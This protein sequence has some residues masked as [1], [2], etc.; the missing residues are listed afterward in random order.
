MRPYLFTTILLA[1]LTMSAAAAPAWNGVSEPAPS[2]AAVLH[3]NDSYTE[4]EFT[5][6]G[7][8]SDF[9]DGEY[10]FSFDGNIY[11]D[12]PSYTKMIAIPEYREVRVELAD[13]EYE[14]INI[15]CPVTFRDERIK[16]GRPGMMRDIRIVPVTVFPLRQ[17]SEG[18]IE[19]LKSARIK[20]HY[21]GYSS[22][23]NKISSRPRSSAFE[24][25]YEKSVLNYEWLDGGFEP[26]GKGTYLV[27]I[28]ESFAQS[29]QFYDWIEWKKM[30]GFHVEVYHPAYDM[31]PEELLN[32]ITGYYED[33][34][35]PL[36]Y[37]ILIGDENENATGRIQ[38]FHV[39]H[40][41]EPSEYDVT[42][43][44]YTTL[45][46]D[47]IFSD[48]FIGRISVSTSFEANKVFIKMLNY[49]KTPYVLETQWYEQMLSVAG[50]YNDSGPAPITP[51]QTAWWIADEFLDHGYTAADTIFYWGPWDPNQNHEQI[52]A[53]INAGKAFVT[54]RGWADANGWQ[55]PYYNIS[56]LDDLVNLWKLPVVLS[57]VCNTGDFGSTN[58]PVCFGEEF[59]RMGTPQN[60]N[61]AIAFLGPSDLHTNT[62]YNNTLST[63]MIQ[64]FLDLGLG[65]F[66][67]ATAY[68]KMTLFEGYP[69]DEHGYVP[70]YFSVYNCLGDPELEMW[71]L[72]PSNLSL[73]CPGTL[74]TGGSNIT[75]YV[76]SG[77]VP[78]EGAYVSALHYGELI[79]GDFTNSSGKVMLAFGPVET[80]TI[81]LTATKY[82]HIPDIV[83][84]P[85]GDW[86][87]HVGYNDDELLNESN[88]DGSLNPG[89]SATLRVTVKNYGP[90]DKTNVEAELTTSCPFL[91]SIDPALISLGDLAAGETVDADY[92]IVMSG[93]APSG[94]V[95]EFR[96]H[97]TGDDLGCESKFESVVDGCEL[98]IE[99]IS[100][101]SVTP[102]QQDEIQ[103]KLKNNGGFIALDVSISLN[104]FDGSVTVINGEDNLGDIGPGQVSD[105]SDPLTIQV[106]GDVY[107]GREIQMRLE[108]TPAVGEAHVEEFVIIA[109]DP[110]ATDPGGPDPYGYFAYD[111]SDTDYA[112]A[113]VYDWIELDPSYGG[114]GQATRLY[115][116]DDS[117]TTVDLPFDFQFY[118]ETYDQLTICTN[119]W[120]SL[121]PTW[122]SNFRNWDLPS[123]PG[124][125]TMIC[126]FW[127][128]LKDTTDGVLDIYYWHDDAAGKFIVEWSR[129]HN[130]YATLADRMETFEVIL[131]D[132][133]IQSGTTGDGDILVQYFEVNDVDYDNNYVT[134]GLQDADHLIGLE[135]VYALNYDVHPTSKELEDEMA[136]LFTTTPP[137]QYLNVDE[138]QGYI[139]NAYSLGPN[140]PNPFN[141]STRV[142]FAIA[143]SGY[144]EL[145]VFDI[146][147][148]LINTLYSGSMVPGKYSR[149]WQGVDSNGH[150]AAS[151]VYFIQLKSDEYQQSIK[152]IL[153][154]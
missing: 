83:E 148:R 127:D 131:F 90:D 116:T 38:S 18:K 72:A 86:W 61:G 122:M 152:T 101:N 140:F 97:V 113:P 81:T 99:E 132:P 114:S 112:S 52:N 44:P 47:D 45:E 133:A 84:I 14:E 11:T 21:E 13:L 30:K 60:G 64:G 147:G 134:V 70:F 121:L 25:L 46:G 117:S 16:V 57:F 149:S 125:A 109:G 48:V 94:N 40:P 5:F 34:V 105:Y 77:G 39:Q 151:G 63:G 67:V 107:T 2:T 69:I 43:H 4:L 37:V 35:P 126:P 22:V 75:A 66:A 115:M 100:N 92:D 71:K 15:D 6:E 42:D 79:A 1:A 141:N 118:G 143:K 154:K 54:Y 20:L 58:P 89:E 50:N 41:Q 85:L 110:E 9:A 150:A 82:S 123:P 129:V 146:N 28:T 53:S 98:I 96:L 8:Y 65:N 59:I 76:Y 19:L 128:D 80:D 153:L 111:D 142:S 87:T 108:I 62:K 137:D 139:P 74:A 31:S 135:Y 12:L 26:Y 104:S 51:C 124:P 136:I 68:G 144:T 91:E 24:A 7:L 56:H 78:Q 23:N 95:I 120:V 49:E 33:S 73:N 32:V 106:E 88:P 145:S 138:T 3:H 130:R 17:N 29:P 55:Y 103:V 93:G 36:E 27:I 10:S 102:G 119:G